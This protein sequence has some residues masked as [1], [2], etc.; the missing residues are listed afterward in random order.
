[1]ADDDFELWLGRV[2]K[3]RPFHHGILKSA[4]LAGGLKRF[5]RQ[6][7]KFDGSRIGRG[8]GMGR[9]LGSSNRHSGDRSRRAIVKAR[10]ARLAGKGARAAVAHVRYL[11]RDGT[12]R[13][14]ERGSLYSAELDAADGKAFLDRGSEDRHQFRFIVAPEDGAEYD[15][16]KPLIRRLMTQ[17]EKDLGTKLDWV[18]VDHFNTGHAHSHILVRGKDDQGKDLIIAREYIT[19]GLRQRAV[20]L[21]NLDLGPRTNREIMRGNLR[22]ISQERFTRIDRRLLRAID[23]EGLVS[24]SHRDAIEQ[25]LRAGRLATLGRMGLADEEQR[26]RWR[27][28]ENLEPTLRAMGRR[29]DIIATLDREVRSRSLAVSPVDYAVYDPS[30]GQAEPIIGQVLTRGLSDEE[31]DREYLIVDAID[32][33]THY[34][35]IG[36]GGGA[37]L[38]IRE[39]AVV[40]IKPTPVEARDVDR[41]VAEIAV[42]NGG[43]YSED[44]HI[45]L[46]PSASERFVEAHVR[47]LEALRRGKAGVE[48]EADGSWKIAP[49]HVERAQQYERARATSEPVRVD[50][51][52]TLRLEEMPNHNGITWLD[53]D[54]SLSQPGRLGGGLGAKVAN[55]LRQRQQWLVQQALAEQPDMLEKLRARELQRVARQLSRELGLGYAEAVPGD[56]IEGIYRRPVQVGSARMALIENSREFTLVPWRPVLERRIGREVSGVMRGRDVSWTF[57]RERSGPQIG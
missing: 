5:A 10:I 56:P 1:M 25:S 7:R 24:P 37:D 40:R 4:N 16:L 54:T 44:I 57:G 42:R 39:G 15:D 8:S 11:Q 12:T 9:V 47:R 30:D 36:E 21:V 45:L 20:D 41:T 33:R 2:A 52:S 43:R 17:A 28:A 53:E 26:G 55:A 38:T 3:E 34:V 19:K 46:D 13:E 18:A 23:A 14:G 35:E 6:A 50:I 51:L 31:T 49:D 29:S 27:L 32:G 22:E 48:R